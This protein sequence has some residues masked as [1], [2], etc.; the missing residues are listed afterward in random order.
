MRY[1]RFTMAAELSAILQGARCKY[2]PAGRRKGLASQAASS[3]RM[4]ANRPL[5]AHRIR[6]YKFAFH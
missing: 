2:S 3:Y 5:A 1:V 4:P 6:S